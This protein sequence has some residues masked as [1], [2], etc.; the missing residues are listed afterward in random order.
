MYLYDLVFL[1]AKV[2]YHFTVHIL[3]IQMKSFLCNAFLSNTSCVLLLS[4][5]YFIDTWNTLCMFHT[6]H[7]LDTFFTLHIVIFIFF[8]MFLFH[9]SAISNV[10]L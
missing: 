10:L 6:L 8:F 4:L 2:M 9:D 7:I 3:N 1:A 5:I